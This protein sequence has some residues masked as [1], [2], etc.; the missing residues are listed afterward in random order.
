[1]IGTSDAGRQ[2]ALRSLLITALAGLGALSGCGKSIATVEGKITYQGK[3]LS[4]GEIH[5]FGEDKSCRSGVIGSDGSYVVSACP[6]GKAKVAIVSKT[7]KDL[8]N[9]DISKLD[10][11]ALEKLGPPTWVAVVPAKYNNPAQSGLEYVV[12]SGKQ[13]IDIAL[14]D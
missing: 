11:A 2:A 5:F 6:I 3:P 12:R 10:P 7:L 13:R 4:T 1:M 9:I 8:P 14:P